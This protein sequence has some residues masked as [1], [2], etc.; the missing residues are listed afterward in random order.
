MASFSSYRPSYRLNLTATPR[1]I[2][3]GR[4]PGELPL[5]YISTCSRTRFEAANLISAAKLRGRM[6][7]RL[8]LDHLLDCIK[9]SRTIPRRSLLTMPLI[10][11]P[12][13]GK[14]V[15]RSA[16]SKTQGSETLRTRK[17]RDKTNNGIRG[18]RFAG[19]ETVS[20]QGHGDGDGGSTP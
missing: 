19:R 4:A 2:V 10:I 17:L 14:N 5:S 9:F 13:S 6:L 18:E 3:E 11:K 12:L 15:L 20:N 7:V 1:I 8:P 16:S